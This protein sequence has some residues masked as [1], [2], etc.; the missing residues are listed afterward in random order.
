M[1]TNSLFVQNLYKTRFFG[2]KDLY[3]TRFLPVQNS[4]FK[5]AFYG[6]LLGAYV[7]ARAREQALNKLCLINKHS[8]HSFHGVHRLFNL[9]GWDG[10][11]NRPSTRVRRRFCRGRERHGEAEKAKCEG[12]A[13]KPGRDFS[14][15]WRGVISYAYKRKFINEL[16]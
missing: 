9:G 5:S 8:A 4:L 12:D 13:K 6:P 1:Q 3:K 14:R 7:R 16:Q 15:A 11:G 10:A 2:Q